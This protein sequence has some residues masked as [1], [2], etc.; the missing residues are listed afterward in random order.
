MQLHMLNYSIDKWSVRTR[1][2]KT[3][4]DQLVMTVQYTCVLWNVKR[5][6]KLASNIFLCLRVLN[7][8]AQVWIPA[9]T[10]KILSTLHKRPDLRGILRH[11]IPRQPNERRPNATADSCKTLSLT[12]PVSTMLWLCYAMKVWKFPLPV[13]NLLR[14]DVECL[15]YQSPSKRWE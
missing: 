13:A 5:A 9:P 6:G 14:F 15:T 10:Y 7:D 11:R 4:S 3:F 8:L 12:H 1:Q 2:K